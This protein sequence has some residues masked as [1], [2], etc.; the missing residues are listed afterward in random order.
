MNNRI[1]QFLEL[2][3]ILIFISSNLSSPHANNQSISEMKK[4]SPRENE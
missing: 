4:S 2:E 1:R 3:G